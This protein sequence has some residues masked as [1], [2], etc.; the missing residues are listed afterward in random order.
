[1][2]GRPAESS[3]CALVLAASFVCGAEGLFATQ[4]QLWWAMCAVPAA[5]AAA[6]TIAPHTC[7]APA[8]LVA[9]AAALGAIGV[10]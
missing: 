6:H 2:G 4:T 7:G 5:A 8:M 3:A 9:A 1:L 10:L